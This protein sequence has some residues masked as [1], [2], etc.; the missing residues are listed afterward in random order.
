MTPTSLHLDRLIGAPPEDVWRAFTT[1]E[2][3]ATWWWHTW[4]DTR[5]TIDARVGGSYRIEAAAHGIAVH[6]EYRVLDAPNRLAF[7]WIWC[8]EDDGMMVEGPIEEVEVTFTA[9][10]SGTRVEVRHTGPWT[11]LE[12]AENYRQGWDF[13]LDALAGRMPVTP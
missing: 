5:Y 12:P 7:S 4:P 10:G 9:T 1:A 3:L 8:D 2:G 11:T 6:G 13:V